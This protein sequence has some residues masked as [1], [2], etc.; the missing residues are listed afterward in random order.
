MTEFIFKVPLASISAL[1]AV[2]GLIRWIYLER[3]PIDL[4]EPWRREPEWAEMINSESRISRQRKING[5]KNTVVI[6][7]LIAVVLYFIGM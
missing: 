5:W 2:I 7:S 1:I 3:K 6:F 4:V